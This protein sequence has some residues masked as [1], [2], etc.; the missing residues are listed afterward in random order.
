VLLG[1]NNK[2]AGNYEDLNVFPSQPLSASRVK[3]VSAG[4]V[5]PKFRFVQKNEKQ[6]IFT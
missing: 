5:F 2:P 3:W 1:I 6:N 4:V